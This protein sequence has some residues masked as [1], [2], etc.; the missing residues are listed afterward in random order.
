MKQNQKYQKPY[1]EG[2]AINNNLSPRY[3][4]NDMPGFIFFEGGDYLG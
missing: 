2:K 1:K 4:R 3:L